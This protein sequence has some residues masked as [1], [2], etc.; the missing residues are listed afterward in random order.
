[1]SRFAVVFLIASSVLASLIGCRRDTGKSANA[2]LVVVSIRQPESR[3]VTEFVDFTGRTNAKDNVNIIPRVTGYLIPTKKPFRE[4]SYVKEDEL[5]FEI[6]PRTYQAQYDAAKAKVT[7]S[8]ASLR[9]AQVTNERFKDLKKK[10]ASAVSQ[11]DLDKYQAQEDE[12][13]ANLSLAEANLETAQLNLS[14]TK[15]LSP[16]AGKVSRYYYTKGNLVTQDQT[17]L[18]TIVSLDPMYVFFD[19]DEATYLR[20]KRADNEGK[21]KLFGDNP[22]LMGLQG[23]EGFPHQGKINFI[24]NQVLAA[25]GSISWRGEVQN[26]KGPAGE[27]LLAPGMF[28]RTRLPIGEPHDAL[29]ISNK[30]V[31]SDQGNK[32]VYVID[33]ENKIVAKRVTTGAI[34]DDGKCVVEGL[35][36]DDWVVVSNIQQVRPKMLVRPE[37][38]APTKAPPQDKADDKGKPADK[39]KGK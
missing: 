31:W 19:M 24:D 27:F 1:M 36:A 34:Q 30:V 10:E 35:N 9:L 5:L 18:T 23:E 20:I 22:V 6:D 2:E 28:V 14:W 7:L 37:K 8:A 39:E 15:V 25:T 16:I 26:P 33:A 4:G 17:I 13:V 11:Q 38:V 3:M 32:N 12:A 29:V 21:I